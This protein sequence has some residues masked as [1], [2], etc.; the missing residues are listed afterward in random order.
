[1]IT[2]NIPPLGNAAILEDTF[3]SELATKHNLYFGPLNS[4]EIGVQNFTRG[5]I[6]ESQNGRNQ[7]KQIYKNDQLIATINIKHG[8]KGERTLTLTEL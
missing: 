8:E 4:K 3:V 6:I 5:E 7:L 2:H 1:M